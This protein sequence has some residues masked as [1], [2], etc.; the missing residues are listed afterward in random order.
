MKIRAVR[1]NGW[2]HVSI[3]FGPRP[4]HGCHPFRAGSGYGNTFAEALRNAAGPRFPH[5]VY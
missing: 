1:I 4:P 2:W 5:G 3:D